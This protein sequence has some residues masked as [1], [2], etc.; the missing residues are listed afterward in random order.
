MITIDFYNNGFVVKNH[1]NYDEYGQDI[2]CAGI[3]AITMGC[4]T[5]FNK[6][7][8]V[9]CLIDESKPIIKFVV[10][11]NYK[12]GIALDLIQNQIKQVYQSYQKYINLSVHNKHL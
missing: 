1:A 4:I 7:D 3:S 8:I 9:E 11:L 5:W 6:D 10:K 2:V 12:N